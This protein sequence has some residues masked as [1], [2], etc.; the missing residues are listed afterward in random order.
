MVEGYAYACIHVLVCTDK[1]VCQL[2]DIYLSNAC[3]V[4][5]HIKLT[6]G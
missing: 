5:K 3:P 4:I 2:Y 1:C 6:W